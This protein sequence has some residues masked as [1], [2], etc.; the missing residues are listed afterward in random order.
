MQLK[1]PAI[2]G[3]ASDEKGFKA[4]QG[5]LDSF[6]NHFNLQIVQLTGESAVANEKALKAHPEQQKKITE[7]TG[8]CLEEVLKGDK[9][10]ILLK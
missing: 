10:L 9:N 2:E 4:N 5:W 3:E 6:R 7:E 1:P 8:Y